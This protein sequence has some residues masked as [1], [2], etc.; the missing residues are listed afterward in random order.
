MLRSDFLSLRVVLHTTSTR[1]HQQLRLVKAP[2]GAL[3]PLNRCTAIYQFG[4]HERVESPTASTQIHSV[5]S[6]GAI[7]EDCL[8]VV[9]ASA[10]LSSGY[11]GHYLFLCNRSVKIFQAA[12]PLFGRLK[13]M[14]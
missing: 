13:E 7:A 6:G 14:H 4:Q 3:T 12:L 2:R 11:S 5:Q 8:E 9:G 1:N 10:Y